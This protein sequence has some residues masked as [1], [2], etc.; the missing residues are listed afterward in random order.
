MNFCT[1]KPEKLSIGDKGAKC[2]IKGGVEYE[3]FR[4]GRIRNEVSIERDIILDFIKYER[5]FRTDITLH[6]VQCKPVE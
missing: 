6:R 1:G 3:V 2:E 5:V 4:Q